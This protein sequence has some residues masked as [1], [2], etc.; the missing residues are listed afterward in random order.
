[1]IWNT[2]Q[3]ITV[4]VVDDSAFMR[5]VIS[6]ILNSDEE[7]EVIDTAKNGLEAIEKAHKLKPD[8]ITLDLKMPVMDGL[9]CLR[10]LNENM[11]IPVI[12]LSSITREGAEATIQAL[13]E[14]AMDF[15]AKPEN[16]F[17]M[18]EEC[19]KNEIIEKVKVAK[20][21][22]CLK[23]ERKS[24]GI[25]MKADATKSKIRNIVVIGTSTGGP[26]ALQDVVPL[27]P[28]NVDA[29]FLVVQHMPEGFTKSLA[30]RLDAL[31]SVK[32][33]EAEDNDILENSHVYI[34]PGDYHMLL[35]KTGNDLFKIKL[36]KDPPIGGHRPSVDVMMESVS[37]TG[38]GNIVGV[39]MTG[40][41][42]DGTEGVK[43]LK[44]VNNAHIIAQDEST[45]V[46]FGM[47]RVAITTGAVDV[48][49][50]L[51]EIANEIMKIVG[52]H[53]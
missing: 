16:I 23:N 4:L 53:E 22:K 7:V 40:M 27:F 32:V 10:K 30:D 34:A 47:P 36:S 13:A 2:K 25:V 39:I 28:A 51:K 12:M 18:K 14:G 6:D 52:V 45:C 35:E 1:M 46:V 42:R 15:I 50:P 11:R 43:K 49:V 38:F 21:Y 33:K 19:I 17:D 44:S 8:V 29:A 31:S 48:V 37:N 3:K 41:G 20:S 9:E 26:R 5:K 24:V